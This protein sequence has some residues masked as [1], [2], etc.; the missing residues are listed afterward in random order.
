[1][2]CLNGAYSLESLGLSCAL[3]ES[4]SDS[5]TASGAAGVSVV[6]EKREAAHCEGCCCRCCCC[7]CRCDASN[8]LSCSGCK[9]GPWCDCSCAA[10]GD[11]CTS[12]ARSSASTTPLREAPA[13]EASRSP[14]LV[15]WAAARATEVEEIIVR[16]LEKRSPADSWVESETTLEN[17]EAASERTPSSKQGVSD[18]SAALA[19]LGGAQLEKPCGAALEQALLWGRACGAWSSVATPSSSSAACS[20][21]SAVTSAVGPGCAAGHL[22]RGG[23]AAK[24]SKPVAPS[25][26]GV[27]MEAGGWFK[28]C[29]WR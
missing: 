4:I 18:A 25:R 26:L 20:L 17:K 23:K 29:R 22:C 7:C 28:G 27:R 15:A 10:W 8:S 13:A 19:A 11:S 3:L 24:L 1:M 12:S 21:A 16:R 5:P 9:R 6:A 2:A 14:S